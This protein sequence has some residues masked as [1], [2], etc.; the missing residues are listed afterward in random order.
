MQL[1]KELDLINHDLGKADRELKEFNS[2]H[3]Q[4]KEEII[5]LRTDYNFTKKKRWAI[6]DTIELKTLSI[7]PFI[8]TS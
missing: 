8:Q 5:R 7:L 2:K 1:S 4:E 3:V 6:A